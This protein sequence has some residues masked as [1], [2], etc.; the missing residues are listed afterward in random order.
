VVLGSSC[1]SGPVLFDIDDGNAGNDG[2]GGGGGNSSDSA[3]AVVLG[4]ADCASGWLF[5]I[6]ADDGGRGNGRGSCFFG[7]GFI[8][9][10]GGGIGNLIFFRGAPGCMLLGD[11]DDDDSPDDGG[12]ALCSAMLGSHSARRPT[13][14]ATCSFT[15]ENNR[16]CRIALSIGNWLSL[17]GMAM[18]IK[19]CIP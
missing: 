18:K 1:A 9:G 8:A 2:T 19:I 7:L 14:I 3:T 10:R 11:D 13:A 17:V 12:C 5:D 4:S 16:A 15:K 6:E